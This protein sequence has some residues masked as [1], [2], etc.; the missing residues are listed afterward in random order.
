MLSGELVVVGKNKAIINL[1]NKK[2]PDKVLVHFKDTCE[3]VPCNSGV[4]DSLSWSVSVRDGK[5]YYLTIE[6]E[7]NGVRE[8]KWDAFW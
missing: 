4:L 5:H 7:V 8:I 3:I 1:H 6:W 2:H